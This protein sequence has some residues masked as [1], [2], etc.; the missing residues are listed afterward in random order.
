MVAIDN[1]I[2]RKERI[3]EKRMLLFGVVVVVVSLCSSNALATTLGPPVAGLDA[4]K[5]SIGF[6]YSN[7]DIDYDGSSKSTE[8]WRASGIS[9]ALTETDKSK[10]DGSIESNM[11]LADLGYGVTDKLEVDV[12]LGMADLS[13]DDGFDG[14]NDFAYGFGVKGSFY[15]EANLKVGV[16]FQM[17]WGS[18]DDDFKDVVDIP[19]TGESVYTTG[20]V[21][22][23][24]YQLKLAVGPS[25][26]LTEGISIY[27]GPFY[28]LFSGDFDSK[29]V[30]QVNDIAIP[31]EPGTHDVTYLDKE[32]GDLDE[33]SNFGGY[34]G[35]QIDIT[36]KLPVSF[37]YQFVSGGGVFGA[38]LLYRF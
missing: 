11:Y 33:D 34:I 9:G 15:E 18:S 4:G 27:G 32:S 1:N 35:A 6:D 37:E 2:Y 19:G 31:G 36:E 21:D 26:K 7:T 10:F 3:M 28:Y 13:V 23:D 25:Y 5:F 38:S 8:E 22:I 24:Y 16:L 12:L 29:V 17:V 30:G 14:G 20:S